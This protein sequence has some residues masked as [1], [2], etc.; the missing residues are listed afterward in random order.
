MRVGTPMA[1]PTTVTIQD[2]PSRHSPSKRPKI[3]HHL[4]RLKESDLD[5]GTEDHKDDGEATPWSMQN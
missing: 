3:F 1:A 2:P 4:P 5:E